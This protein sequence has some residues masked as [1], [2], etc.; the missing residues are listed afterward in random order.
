MRGYSCIGLWQPK[1]SNNIGSV[2]RAAGCFGSAFVAVAGGRYSGA[3]TDTQKTYRHIPLIE[4][5]DLRQVLPK[6]CVPI[7]VDLILEAQPLMNFWHPERAFYIFGGE[8]RT[9]DNDILAWC[10]ERIFIPSNYCLNLA[11]AINVV[12]YDRHA[13]RSKGVQS[14][15]EPYQWPH[16]KEETP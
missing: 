2:L 5:T 11:A 15:R 14:T 3:S 12:L 6:D 16:E 4:T 9:L 1:D 13:K 10:K 8:D 7:A